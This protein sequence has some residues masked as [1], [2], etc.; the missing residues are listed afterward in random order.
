MFK[1]VLKLSATENSFLAMTSTAAAEAAADEFFA[2]LNKVPTDFYFERK[3]V[4]LD[5]ENFRSTF[6]K[7]FKRLWQQIFCGLI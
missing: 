6:S 4:R 1:R 3:P 5:V 2:F 7:F